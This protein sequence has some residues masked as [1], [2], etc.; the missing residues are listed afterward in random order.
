M[1]ILNESLV[2]V[3]RCS[4]D[5]LAHA[6]REL[7][8]VRINLM[9]ARVRVS[10][11]TLM[12]MASFMSAT[13][14]VGLCDE[15][16]L[17]KQEVELSDRL[18]GYDRAPTGLIPVYPAV[19]PVPHLTSLYGS[20]TD[21][22]GSRRDEA[23]S[24]V[25][26]GELGDMVLV[27]GRGT[28]VASWRADWGWGPEGALLLLHSRSDLGLKAGAPFYYSAFYHL[29]FE[30]IS[31][32]EEGQ[33]LERGETFARVWR[34]GGNERFLP[35]VHWEVYEVDEPDDIY[36]VTNERGYPAWDNDTSRLIDP[37]YLM[38]PEGARKDELNVPIPV[39]ERQAGKGTYRGFTY[40][41]APGAKV[42]NAGAT[43]RPR[44]RSSK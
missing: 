37:L 12:L 10:R 39:F 4:A 33:I 41:L 1:K 42:R 30:D 24:G 23:H 36:W 17:Q 19:T 7:R 43:G 44:W 35:E 11:L 20:W 6:S 3:K 25:D 32:L 13:S 18:K 15:V 9:Q 38:R 5:G 8:R 21:V 34:P 26:G 28:V 40:I 14:H 22:D 29:R 2:V 16:P 31:H 27:P